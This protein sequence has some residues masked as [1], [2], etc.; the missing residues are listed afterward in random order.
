MES[1]LAMPVVVSCWYGVRVLACYNAPHVRVWAGGDTR[2][3]LSPRGMHAVDLERVGPRGDQRISYNF[4]EYS[5]LQRSR[6]KK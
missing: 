2:L 3:A 6:L 4:L 5:L 1:R